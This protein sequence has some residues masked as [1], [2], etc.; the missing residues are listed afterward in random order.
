M[1]S[2]G[3]R[4]KSINPALLGKMSLLDSN[5]LFPTWSQSES[6][7]SG[8]PPPVLSFLFSCLWRLYYLT[9]SENKFSTLQEFL[10]VFVEMHTNRNVF[11]EV[12]LLSTK[13]NH[14]IKQH[15]IFYQGQLD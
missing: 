5:C 1:I 3:G 8:D 11:V 13:K 4:R 2:M 7:N 10:F 12:S 9:L 14:L 6:E 15:M